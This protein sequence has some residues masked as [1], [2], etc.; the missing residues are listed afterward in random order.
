MIVSYR[1]FRFPVMDLGLFNRHMYSLARLDFSAN[2]LKGFNLLG[3]HAHIFMVFLVPFYLLWPSA[4]FL[5]FVQT[6]CITLSLFPIYYIAKHYLKSELVSVFWLISYLLFFGL[7][8]AIG[9]PFHDS[10][11]AVLPI[12]WALYYLLVNKKIKYL[13][14]WLIVLC[15]IREDMPLVVAMFGIYL[16]VIE[17]RW[18]IGSAIVAGSLAYMYIIL[19]F[20]MPALGPGYAY[21]KNPFG[22]GF[23]DVLKASLLRPLEVIKSMFWNP[24]TKLV[25]LLSMILSFGGLSLLAP[26][27]LLLMTPLWMG[28]T[29]TNEPH[30]WWTSQHYSA[31]QAPFLV[32]SAIVGLAFLIYIVKKYKLFSKKILNIL[33]IIISFAVILCS[34]TILI[35]TKN[36]AFTRIFEPSSYMLGNT[37]KSLYEAMKLIPADASLG[38]QSPLA[39]LTS[40][41][42]VY[43]LPLKTGESAEYILTVDGIDRY[44]FGSSKA[45]NSYIGG[46]VEKEGYKIIYSKNKVVLLKK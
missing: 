16:A 22:N 26:Q 41:I 34:L 30:R 28:R 21:S 32:V 36:S 27:V 13:V 39:Q 7:W 20:L 40:R 17:K 43:H 12:S 24:K 10:P 35:K 37:E 42:N 29:I 9:Y 6:M 2:P 38:V 31:S 1:T 15:L 23:G 46:L 33:V 45:I 5:L 44:Q 11:V 3:D 14:F 4:G 8:A 25:T 18:R 19:N